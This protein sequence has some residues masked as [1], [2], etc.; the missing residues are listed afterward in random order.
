M[1]VY[2][3]IFLVEVPEALKRLENEIPKGPG[4][5]KNTTTY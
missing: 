2:T 3:R 1:P 5:I 4:R